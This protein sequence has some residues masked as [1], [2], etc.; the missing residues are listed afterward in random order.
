VR[1]GSV[2][3]E[4]ICRAFSAFADL[5]GTHLPGHSLHVTE[6]AD[7]AAAL[8]GLSAEEQAQLHTAAL[9]HDLGRVGVPSAIW[10]R[11]GP[12]GPAD[13]ERV[14][15]HPYWTG[16]ILSRC[17]AFADVE[18][19]AGAHHERLGGGGYHRGARAAELTRSQRLLGAADV[20]AA[21]SEDRPHRAA[22]TPAQAAAVLDEEVAAGRLDAECV[23]ALAE[24]AG[25][26]RVRA[27]WPCDLRTRE[28]EVLRLVVRGLTNREIGEELFLS[29][30]TVQHHL[31]SVYDKTGQRTRAG[32][33][34][35]A[36][37]HG[38]VPSTPAAQRA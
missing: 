2:E 29:A 31:A 3:F 5:K 17:P 11:P 7:R 8:L 19:L 28:V 37:Q 13:W 20:F 26:P 18:A 12:L 25:L 15:L 14:R 33:A 23:A 36:I 10:D 35:F 6:L 21:L 1:A 27:A 4:G 16:R 22:R 24:A 9:L 32:A 30:R 34:V 38:L